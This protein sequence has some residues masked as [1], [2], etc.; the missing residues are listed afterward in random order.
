MKNNMNVPNVAEVSLWERKIFAVLFQKVSIC[1]LFYE[2]SGM[3]PMQSK[4]YFQNNN[5][6]CNNNR[7]KVQNILSRYPLETIELLN[8]LYCLEIVIKRSSTYVKC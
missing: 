2:R 4:V 1:L 7:S 5:R 3:M 8:N 6:H